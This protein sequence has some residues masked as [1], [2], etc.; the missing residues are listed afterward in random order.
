MISKPALEKSVNLEI[1]NLLINS[2]IYLKHERILKNSFWVLLAFIVLGFIFLIIFNFFSQPIYNIFWI[3]GLCLLVAGIMQVGIINAISIKNI[4]KKIKKLI[5]KN[6]ED[7]IFNSIDNVPNMKINKLSN[8]FEYELTYEEKKY[9]LLI[10]DSQTTIKID[11]ITRIVK[12]ELFSFEVCWSTNKIIKKRVSFLTSLVN[13]LTE[14]FT[15]QIYNDINVI[16]K[17]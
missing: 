12:Y 6:K 13:E 3:L 16:M 9:E 10:H 4:N 11:G 15:N 2:K 14:K 7:I 5:E 1:N 17:V 8:K